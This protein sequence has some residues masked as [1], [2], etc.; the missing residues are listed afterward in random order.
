MSQPVSVSVSISLL[1]GDQELL[2]TQNRLP[3][4]KIETVDFVWKSTCSLSNSDLRRAGPLSP[5]PRLSCNLGGSL[6][7]GM[8]CKTIAIES[9]HMFGQ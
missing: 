2:D 4:E 9:S 8:G 5:L 7:V 1:W 6:L 3:E